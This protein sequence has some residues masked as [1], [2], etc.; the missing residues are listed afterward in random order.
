MSLRKSVDLI[1]SQLEDTITDSNIGFCTRFGVNANF[2]VS[3]LNVDAFYRDILELSSQETDKYFDSETSNEKFDPTQF[4]LPFC[5]KTG[6]SVPIIVDMNFE[7]PNHESTQFYDNNFLIGVSKVIQ[8]TICSFA[9]VK[10]DSSGH[11]PEMRCFVLE[12]HIWTAN[13]KQYQNVRFQFPF[14]KIP[15]TVLNGFLINEIIIELTNKDFVRKLMATPLITDWNRII[16]KVDDCVSMYGCKK[17]QDSAPFILK[18]IYSYISDEFDIDSKI[19]DDRGEEF[20]LSYEDEEALEP[21]NSSLVGQA[22]INHADIASNDK[23]FNLPLLLSIHFYSKFTSINADRIQIGVE[24]PVKLFIPKV[25]GFLESEN[26]QA[27]M[28]SLLPLINP[29]RCTKAQ[30][31]HWYVMGKCIH[32]IYHGSNN[33]YILFCDLS[34]DDLKDEC[35][36]VWEKFASEY[37]DIRTLMEYAK[38]DSPEPFKVWHREYYNPLISRAVSG[39]DMLVAELVKRILCLEFLYCRE[40]KTWYH[41]HRSFL[42]KDIGGLELRNTIASR[43]KP[44]YE[45]L[46]GTYEDSRD[47][48]PTPDQKKIYKGMIAEVDRLLDK[49]DSVD[50]LDKVI[51]ASTGKL[52]DDNFTELRDENMNTIACTNVVLECYDDT[53]CYRQGMIQDYIT[54]STRIAFPISYTDDT[55]QVKYLKKYYG[56]VHTD[57]EACHFFLKDMASFLIGGNEEKYFRNWIGESNASKSQVVKLIQAALGDYCIDFP[58]EVITIS[59]G[60]SSGGP[61]PALEQAKGTRVAFVAETDR[62]EPL[63]VGKIKKY[64]GNDRYWNRS[65]HK[66]GGSRALT[67]KLIHM[68]NVIAEIPNP[69]EA[70]N[71]REVIYPFLSKWMENP[72]A[73]EEE[74]YRQRKFKMDQNFSKQINSLAQAQLYLMFS[75]FPVYREEGIRKLPAIFKAKTEAHHRE[76][77]PFYNFIKEKIVFLHINELEKTPDLTKTLDIFSLFQ[78]YRRWFQTFSPET[79]ITVNQNAFKAEMMK[80][81]RLGCLNELNQWSGIGLRTVLRG[82]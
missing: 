5:E 59:R 20:Y 24:A 18:S 3:V 32:N 76:I 79:P 26:Q 48:A 19:E 55:K 35:E 15:K 52:Y 81:S 27:M 31:Y 8:D 77:D 16:Q 10:D 78:Q 11:A 39:K 41:K 56:Q 4:G 49:L 42:K 36:G 38:Q 34:D 61:D 70:Y 43:L 12:T 9:K 67:F 33:G 21:C 51:K 14:T 37:L 6:D 60:K 58:N 72:P 50:Y 71:M 40:T 44:I 69:D 75:Y 7:F 53:I 25:P 30:K 13:N 62:S 47:N 74:Q 22:L 68:S 1:Q 73:S 82:Q 57:D 54:K 46:R 23:V 29:D 64:T 63:H 17:T 45:E 66:E 28:N 80:E 65:L 2:S